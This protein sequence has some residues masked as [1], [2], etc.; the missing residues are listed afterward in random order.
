MRRGLVLTV[1]AAMLMANVAPAMSQVKPPRIGAGQMVRPQ[2]HKP[3]RV[4]PPAALAR[5]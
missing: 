4:R 5:Q 3:P 1:L 2:A